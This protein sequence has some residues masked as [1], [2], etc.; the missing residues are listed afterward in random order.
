MRSGL[1]LSLSLLL[2][3]TVAQSLVAPATAQTTDALLRVGYS[4]EFAGEPEIAE[5]MWQQLVQLEP[6]NVSHYSWLGYANLYQEEWAEAEAAFSAGI[7]LPAF[8]SSPNP[9]ALYLGLGR[10]LRAQ[11]KFAEAK[12]ALQ[13]AVSLNERSPFAYRALGRL[14]RDYGEL[15]EAT[16][17]FNAIIEQAPVAPY[18]AEAYWD[19]GKTLT[20]Q[21]NLADAELA[22]RRAIGL[23]GEDVRFWQSLAAVLNQQGG[24]PELAGI[25]STINRLQDET[26]GATADLEARNPLAEEFDIAHYKAQAVE[27][28]QLINRYPA[29]VS[30]Y[31]DLGNALRKIGQ[32]SAAEAAFRQATL[33]NPEN[34]LA[35]YNLGEALTDLGRSDEAEAAH[36][37]ARSLYPEI[38]PAGAFLETVSNAQSLYQFSGPIGAQPPAP[39]APPPALLATTANAEANAET[40]ASQPLATRTPPRRSIRRSTP[41]ARVTLIPALPAISAFPPPRIGSTT[42]PVTDPLLDQLRL[43][44]DDAVS[45]GKLGERLYRQTDFDAAETAFRTM[46]QLDPR[47]AHLAY[48]NL[49]VTLRRQEQLNQAKA[50]FRQAIEAADALPEASLA[51]GD[52]L[53]QITLT[54]QVLGDLLTEQAAWAEVATLYQSAMERELPA[55]VYRSE[56]FW[57]AKRREALLFSAR[58]SAAQ[59]DVDIAEAA[60]IALLRAVD[61]LRAQ[62]GSGII[63]SAHSA[64]NYQVADELATLLFNQG[65][66]QEAEAVY[67]AV[68]TD[69]PTAAQQ[70][71]RGLAIVLNAQ[72]REQEAEELIASFQPSSTARLRPLPPFIPPSPRRQGIT[73]VV[74]QRRTS[75]PASQ[76]LPSLSAYDPIYISPLAQAYYNFGQSR[77]NEGRYG[78]AAFALTR[79][80]STTNRYADALFATGLASTYSGSLNSA[81]SFYREALAADAESIKCYIVP[82]EVA[83]SPWQPED[84]LQTGEACLPLL[85]LD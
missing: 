25:A 65:R 63:L 82:P 69:S 18:G 11:G 15:D 67:S 6:D 13:T 31:I 44:P 81:E 77:L 10:A 58:T 85:L 19:S 3:T 16:A 7:D 42:R 57:D 75:I 9:E 47:Y 5:D 32:F 20:A 66:L 37:S 36:Q 78:Y 54:Y 22:Y 34:P 8:E 23:N 48:H 49:A 56:I 46:A 53:A 83:D 35:Q 24:S 51:D 39:V 17:A 61:L 38:D 40:L 55:P 14:H 68:M 76:R 50:A 26:A 64:T 84:Y 74:P 2:G 79:A 27:A 52:T 72:N 1:V 30:A 28:Q 4:A 12:T 73:Q 45:Q 60:Y 71:Y 62:G 33:L 70:L 59:N 43:N 29:T 41:R 80:R 21:G